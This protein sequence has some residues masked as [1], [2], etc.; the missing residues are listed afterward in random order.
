MGGRIR[1][2]QRLHFHNIFRLL[3]KKKM[4]NPELKKIANNTYVVFC[5]NKTINKTTEIKVKSKSA[6]QVAI[7]VKPDMN[8]H[9][10]MIKKPKKI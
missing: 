9:Q 8:H 7:E 6:I 5:H 10:P 2:H 4:L 1:P 3:K